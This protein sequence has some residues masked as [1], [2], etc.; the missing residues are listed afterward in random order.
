MIY[1]KSNFSSDHGVVILNPGNLGVA[2]SCPVTSSRICKGQSN[3]WKALRGVMWVWLKT[4]QTQ[5]T[6][7]SRA[8][9]NDQVTW[10]TQNY[11]TISINSAGPVT[12]DG[13]AKILVLVTSQSCHDMPKNLGIFGQ[14]SAAGDKK[15]SILVIWLP[16]EFGTLWKSLWWL[17]HFSILEGTMTHD[18]QIEWNGQGGDREKIKGCVGKKVGDMTWGERGGSHIRK[19]GFG[20]KET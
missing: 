2:Q 19:K 4:Q 6:H 8:R 5:N 20:P 14:F 7:T 18:C 10:S 13:P 9:L 12:C 16:N 15:N 1:K 17:W 11:Y 3:S